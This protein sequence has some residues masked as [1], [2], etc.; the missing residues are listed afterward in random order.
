MNLNVGTEKGYDIAAALTGPGI[1]EL[2]ALKVLITG[3]VRRVCDVP[4]SSG[5]LLRTETV[6]IEAV[7]GNIRWLRVNVEK[8]RLLRQVVLHWL[9]HAREAL[10]GLGCGREDW[11]Y[12]FTWVLT[13]LVCTPRGPNALQRMNRLLDTF[14]EEGSRIFG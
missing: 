5:A 11:L 2:G 12:Q 14:T 3:E 7:R 13:N 6:D 1:A 8:H 4:R 9:Y 10:L